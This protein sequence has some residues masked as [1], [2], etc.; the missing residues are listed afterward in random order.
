MVEQHGQVCG[1]LAWHADWRDVNGVITD[2]VKDAGAGFF[3]DEMSA[4]VF[5]VGSDNRGHASLPVRRGGDAR[6]IGEADV[7]ADNDDWSSAEQWVR[8]ESTTEHCVVSV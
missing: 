4:G 5:D 2:A 7:A 8:A 6:L 1:G 3:E